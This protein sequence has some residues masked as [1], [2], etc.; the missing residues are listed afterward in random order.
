[1]AWHEGIFELIDMRTFSNLWFW[2]ALAVL[3]S[4]TSHFVLGVP[5]DLVQRAARKRGQAMADMN[6]ITRVNVNRILFYAEVSGVWLAA[7]TCF[8]LTMLAILG[9]IYR[10]ELCQA[11]FLMGFP[12]SIVGILSI[13]AAYRIRDNNLMDDPLINQLRWY[14]FLFQAIAMVAIFVTSMWG[15]FQLFTVSVLNS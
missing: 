13:K 8:A 10:I 15:M 11:L 7:I 3:W 14:R 4:S 12:I 1:M 9:F 2:I 6:D 5:W